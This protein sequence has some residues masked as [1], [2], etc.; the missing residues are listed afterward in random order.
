MASAVLHKF[1]LADGSKGVVVVDVAKDSPAANK[2]VRAGDL[3]MEA[4][5]EEVKSPGEVSSKIGTR[6]IRVQSGPSSAC[7]ATAVIHDRRLAAI[8]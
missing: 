5:Q 8:C 1:S 4:A 2:G 6:P 3:I 7:A